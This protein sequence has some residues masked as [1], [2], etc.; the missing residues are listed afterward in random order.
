[1]AHVYDMT[2]FYGL[3]AETIAWCRLRVSADDPQSSLRSFVLRPSNLAKTANKWGNFDYEWGTI[4]EKQT[5]VSNL[6]ASRAEL[7]RTKTA[8]PEALPSGLEGG[9]LLIAAPEESDWCCLSEP[10][11]NGFIDDLDVPAWD[12]WVCYVHEANTP[13]PEYVRRTREALY[14]SYNS[15]Q[16]KE[17]QPPAYVSFLICWIPPQFLALVEEGI[18]VN[19]VECFFWAADYKEHHYNTELLRQLDKAGML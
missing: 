9:R 8:F 10:E 18:K 5:V 2:E 11:S 16:Y 12:T 6:A 7:L 14:A 3:L 1:M 4:E 19:P 15:E 13:D 17:W